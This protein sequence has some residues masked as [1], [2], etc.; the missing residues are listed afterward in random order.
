MSSRI[1][2]ERQITIDMTQKKMDAF[3]D[4]HSRGVDLLR[5]CVTGPHPK[6]KKLKKRAYF[7]VSLSRFYSQAKIQITTQRQMGRECHL[8]APIHPYQNIDRKTKELIR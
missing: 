6:S 8:T 4:S 2:K 3:L 5:V 1:P 7:W